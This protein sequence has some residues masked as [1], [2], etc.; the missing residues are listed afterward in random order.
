MVCEKFK[1]EPDL[2]KPEEDLIPKKKNRRKKNR[3]KEK[4]KAVEAGGS[5]GNVES[6]CAQAFCPHD[7]LNDSDDQ[8]EEQIYDFELRLLKQSTSNPEDKRLKPNIDSTWLN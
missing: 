2:C 4:A 7:G 3:K 6:D 1:F 8:F 5:C